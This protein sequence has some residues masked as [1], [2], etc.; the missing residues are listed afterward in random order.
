MAEA[1]ADAD[2]SSGAQKRWFEEKQKKRAAELERLKLDPTQGY[3]WVGG[4]W[5]VTTNNKNNNS[6]NSTLLMLSAGEEG[7]GGGWRGCL[8]RHKGQGSTCR[9]RDHTPSSAVL[10]RTSWGHMPWPSRQGR[11]ALLFA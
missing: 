9:G 4:H 6:P 1:G 5:P 7:G 2:K 3:R 8:L 10:I 11:L